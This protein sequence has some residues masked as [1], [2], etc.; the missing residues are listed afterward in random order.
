[1]RQELYHKFVAL[2]T[3]GRKEEAKAALQEFLASFQTA[4]EKR[5]WVHDFLEHGAYGH[6]IRHELYE[7]LVFPVLL[8]GYN[9][10]EARS[11]YLLAKTAQ[12]LYA[13]RSLHAQIGRK[14]EQ[15]LLR[16]VY[17]LTRDEEVGQN[18]L[19]AN[20]RWFD[21]CQHEWPAGILYGADGA[22]L[23]ECEEILQE[24]AFSLTLAT[25]VEEAYLQEFE[26]RVQEWKNRLQSRA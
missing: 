6:R 18:L 19:R 21:Y 17:D 20:L 23:S 5:A 7:Q 3:S 4:E 15:Q 16:E 10:Q 9:R 8:D 26:S 12:N 11:L 22:S 13:A 14:T 1:M 24:I 25:G 2:N